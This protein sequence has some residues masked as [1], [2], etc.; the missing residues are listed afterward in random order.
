MPVGAVGIRSVLF[1]MLNS[2]QKL[3]SD[4]SDPPKI[5]TPPV[6]RVPGPR[7]GNSSEHS[8]RSGGDREQSRVQG[9]DSEKE[10]QEFTRRVDSAL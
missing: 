6:G 5:S 7:G 4:V 9:E 3:K 10:L 2:N 8:G 1:R